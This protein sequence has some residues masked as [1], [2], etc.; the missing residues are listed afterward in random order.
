MKFLKRKF[1]RGI[2]V[3]SGIVSIMLFTGCEPKQIRV[4]SLDTLS[5][6][7]QTTQMTQPEGQRLIPGSPFG[8]SNGVFSIIM[9]IKDNTITV[10]LMPADAFPQGANQPARPS[11]TNTMPQG[12]MPSVPSSPNP[13]G[14]DTSNWQ[15]TNWTVDDKTIID[16]GQFG[17]S[18]TA[19]T[20]PLKLSDLKVGD[21]VMITERAGQTSIAGQITVMQGFGN[22]QGGGRF[23]SAPT[24][25]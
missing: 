24:K 25:N 13:N 17:G 2:L 18:N 4:N 6:G 15:K 23:P 5:S 11:G 14:L 10:A 21:S 9:E 20:N 19:A 12:S 8:T 3:I 1:I 16:Q 22:N 7:Q